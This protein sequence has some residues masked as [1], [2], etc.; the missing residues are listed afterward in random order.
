MSAGFGAAA[1][2]DLVL[3]V[4]VAGEEVVEPAGETGAGFFGARLAVEIEALVRVGLH[5][6]ELVRAAGMAGDVFPALFADRAAGFHL[7]EDDVVPLDRLALD[8]ARKI[9]TGGERVFWHA[10]GEAQVAEDSW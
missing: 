7:V 9:T 6:V 4:G 1:F 3:R 2:P 8:R 10:V 5:V